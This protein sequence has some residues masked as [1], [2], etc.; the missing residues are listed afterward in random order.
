M[1]ATLLITKGPPM[2]M[3][4][5]IEGVATDDG[6]GLSLIELR[7]EMWDFGLLKARLHCGKAT[8]VM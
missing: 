3:T 5:E 7:E 2:W 6:V 1:G 8:E 4:A